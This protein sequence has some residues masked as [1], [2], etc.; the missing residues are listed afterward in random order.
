M[1]IGS[2]RRTGGRVW[3]ALNLRELRPVLAS[4]CEESRK[5]SPATA[6]R[7]AN[8]T[9]TLKGSIRNRRC[10]GKPAAPKPSHRDEPHDGAEDSEDAENPVTRD[11]ELLE[12]EKEPAANGAEDE[13]ESVRGAKHAAARVVGRKRLQHRLEWDDV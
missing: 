7:L 12:A 6:E 13:R 10:L 11:V 8:R 1:V 9:S 4:T 3:R 5:S 2:S